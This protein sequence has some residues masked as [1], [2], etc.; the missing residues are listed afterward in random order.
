LHPHS[1]TPRSST[2][3]GKRSKGILLSPTQRVAWRSLAIE[4]F[5]SHD[6]IFSSGDRSHQ[7]FGMA[8]RRLRSALP[9]LRE[10]AQ[11]QLLDPADRAYAADL[12]RRVERWSP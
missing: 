6:R 3:A 5:R 8:L 4:V 7:S 9:S 11:D 12:L 1:E 10:M 2:K